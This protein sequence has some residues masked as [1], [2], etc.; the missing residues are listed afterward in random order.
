MRTVCLYIFVGLAIFA[1]GCRNSKYYIERGNSFAASGKFD[2]AS[3]NYRKALQNDANSAEAYFRLGLSEI[4]LEH[5]RDALAELHRATDLAPERDDIRRELGELCLSGLIANPKLSKIPYQCLKD[6]SGQ[7]LAKDPASYSGLRLKGYI[8]LFDKRMGEAIDCFGRTNQ[9]KPN[10]PDVAISL[11]EAL[12]QSNREQDAERIARDFIQANPSYGAAYDALYAHYSERGRMADA[13]EIWTLKVA[14]NPGQPA[15]VTDLARLYWRQGRQKDSLN[16]IAKLLATPGKRASTYLAA[17]DFYGSIAHWQEARNQFEEGMRAAPQQKEL[18][19]KRIANVLLME[20]KPAEAASVVDQILKQ[21]PHDREAIAIRAGLLVARK[22]PQSVAAGIAAY[23]EA[24]ETAPDDS[25]LR[26]KYGQALAVN[27]DLSGA[28]LQFEEAVRIRPDYA[29]PRKALAEFALKQNKPGE[30]VRLCDEAIELD[31]QDSSSRLLKAVASARLGRDS[32]AR[33]ELNTVLRSSPNNSGALLQLALLDIHRGYSKDAEAVLTRLGA[34]QPALA[35][36]GFA[37][38][39][40][41]QGQI[42]RAVEALKRVNLTS[43]DS[44]LIHNMLGALALHAN[45]NDVAIN[46]Y[47]TLLA[48]N[49]DSPELL[50]SLSEAYRRRGEWNNSIAALERVQKVEPQALMPIA[51]LASDLESAGRPDLAV[52]QYRRALTLEPDNPKVLN[53]LAFLIVETEGDVNE[54]L[55]LSQ[56]AVQQ[57]PNDPQFADTLGWVYLKK[58]MPDGALQIFNNLV[59]KHPNDPAFRYHLGAALIQ[60]GAQAKGRAFLESALAKGPSKEDAEKIHA[61]LKKSD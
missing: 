53:N 43:Q 30:T 26:Y 56:R 58:N 55:R 32:D 49:P 14:K 19:Q 36:G 8:A 46:E 60:N 59:A 40:A 38:L 3:L 50:L 44:S 27:G 48:D 24:V 16:L 6:V 15:F 57:A 54:A 13:E 18:F 7:F 25:S 2:E 33:N 61:L 39:F 9:M 47:K 34:I 22:D 45:R 12:I 4:K 21:Q 52:A 41:A 1:V 28:K 51:L 17:G 35:A 5:L 31:P 37:V 23:K 10:Q 11:V 20:G 29:D 42:D